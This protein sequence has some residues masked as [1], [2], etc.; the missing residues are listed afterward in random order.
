MYV[1]T[2]L[3]RLAIPASAGGRND[4]NLAFTIYE[5]PSAIEVDPDDP[6]LIYG[7]TE[8]ASM[9]T[10]LPPYDLPQR[11]DPRNWNQCLFWQM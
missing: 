3:T 9:T 11:D 4:T 7:D 6:A 5:C 1:R 2:I 10:S 8:H